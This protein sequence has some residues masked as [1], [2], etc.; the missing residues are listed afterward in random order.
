MKLTSKKPIVLGVSGI[1]GSGKSSVSTVFEKLGAARIDADSIG[2][3]LLKD[4]NIR[5]RLVD[6]FG[7]RIT[8]ERNQIDPA[9]LAKKA[10]KNRSTVA[11]LNQITH[12]DLIKQLGRNVGRKGKY[13]DV[14]V[15][16]AALLPEWNLRSFIDIL[17]VVDS[18]VESS[19]KRACK[20]RRLRRDQVLSRINLQFSRNKKRKSADLVLPNYGSIDDLVYRAKKLFKF[21]IENLGC[22][23]GGSICHCSK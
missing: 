1:M 17:I 10:F 2:K 14:V 19:I 13:S 16:D 18:P 3:A 6:R 15:I 20:A 12:P 5:K 11:K 4:K 9:R 23:G 22:G 21:I 8:D 7:D